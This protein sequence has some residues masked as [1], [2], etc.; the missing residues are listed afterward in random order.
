MGVDNNRLNLLTAVLQKILKLS[1]W[2][3]DIFVKVTGG[4]KISEPAADLAIC[5]AIV[6]SF[7]NSPVPLKT[8]YFGEVGLLGE[9]RRVSGEE[10][11]IKEAK[12]LGFEKVLSSSSLQSIRDLR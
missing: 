5:Q 8:V 10:K 11:R 9:I 4:F 12:K 1:L 7:K 2:D 3:Q 6:S